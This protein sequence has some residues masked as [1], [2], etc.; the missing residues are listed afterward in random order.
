MAILLTTSY[1]QISTISLTYGEIRTYAKY[2]NQSNDSNQ[3][4]YQLKT[5]YYIPSQSQVSFGSATA[6]IDGETKSYGYTTFYRGESVIQEVGRVITH[7]EDGSSPTKNVATSWTASFGGGGSTSADVYFPKIDRYPMLTSAPNFNDEDN[8]T[9][10]YT[11]TMG[12]SGGVLDACIK[13][14]MSGPPYIPYRRINVSD[15]NYTFNFTNEERVLLRQACTG[16]TL[17]VFFFIRTTANNEAYFS[18]LERTLSIVNGEPTFTTTITETNQD[19]IN[20]LGSSSATNLIKNV[21]EAQVTVT[22][23]AYKEATISGVVINNTTITTSPYQTTIIPT[24]A[25]FNIN[26]IDSRGYSTSGIETRNLI[27]YERVKINS[28]SF[29]RENPTSSDI[30]VNLDCVY[31]SLSDDNLNNP[32]V[33]QY[34]LDDGSFATIPST[35]YVI[36]NTNHKLTITDYEIS[37]VLSYRNQGEFT[38]KVFDSLSET[39]DKIIVIKGIPTMD[40]GEHD[41]QVNGDIY[42]AD[43][44][45]ENEFKIYNNYEYSATEKVV[46]TWFGKP[47]YGKTIQIQSATLNSIVDYAHNIGNVDFIFIKNIMATDTNNNTTRMMDAFISATSMAAQ[48]NRTNITYRIPASDWGWSGRTL[49]LTVIVNYTKTTD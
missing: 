38:I 5:T 35:N 43:T 42:I 3:T 40:L 6:V 23:T 22:P 31:Y 13:L 11:T 25:N 26:V 19:V 33:V 44:D 2:S 37:N 39:S 28:F 21:S 10:T 4:T 15:G 34:K 12:F 14:T 46:G 20:I 45:R 29:E 48:A 24:S 16:K 32:I 36:D 9:I 30:I 17:Q 8:P 18:M 41:L 49:R 47:L 1:Q 27:D 7:N